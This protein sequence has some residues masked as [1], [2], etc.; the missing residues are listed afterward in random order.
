VI[1]TIGLTVASAERAGPEHCLDHGWD[2]S[3]ILESMID[4]IFG[5]SGEITIAG[6]RGPYCSNVTPYW[7]YLTF[8][9]ESPGATAAGGVMWSW[10]PP[11]NDQDTRIP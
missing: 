2:G 4:H 9:C 11:C 7:L 3:V 5:I 10:N 1:W 6:T 8:G